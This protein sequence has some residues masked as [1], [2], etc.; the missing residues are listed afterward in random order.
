MDSKDK[1]IEAA[2]MAISKKAKDTLI[3]ELKTLSTFTDYFIICSGESS[4]QVRTIAETIEEKFSKIKVFPIGR[5]GAH[6]AR[7]VLLDYGDVVIHI[8]NEEGRAYYELEKL[9]LDAPRIP[10]KDEQTV[11]SKKKR[12]D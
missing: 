10:I 2:Q 1:A 11:L 12:R 5:E 7:W 6:S 3:L 9:W 8:F 4:T